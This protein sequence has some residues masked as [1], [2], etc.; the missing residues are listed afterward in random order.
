M[1]K[2][3]LFLPLMILIA[4]GYSAVST[5]GCGI[6]GKYQSYDLFQHADFDTIEFSSGV[7]YHKTCCGDSVWGRYSFEN[8]KYVVHLNHFLMANESAEFIAVRTIWGVQLIAHS[9]N[10]KGHVWLRKKLC[11][12]LPL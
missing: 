4:V 8:G 1:V 9:K 3:R 10:I 7:V 11:T 6:E 2:L 12:D 5:M